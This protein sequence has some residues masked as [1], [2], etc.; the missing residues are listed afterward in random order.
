MKQ[1]F[2]CPSR[3]LN[4]GPPAVD[5]KRNSYQP[6]FSYK[7]K[8]KLAPQ[9]LLGLLSDKTNLNNKT[10]HLQYLIVEMTTLRRLYKLN[11]DRT[12]KILQRRKIKINVIVQLL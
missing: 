10:F 7:K 12:H 6:K 11:K 4:L 5:A 9:C 3:E 2:T 8:S 1:T